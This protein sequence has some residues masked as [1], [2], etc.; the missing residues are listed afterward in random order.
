[1]TIRYSVGTVGIDN[2]NVKALKRILALSATRSVSY[3]VSNNLPAK[4]DIAIVNA[5]DERT[6]F[7]TM[8]TIKA[9]E[10]SV[11]VALATRRTELC[12]HEF[13][14]KLPL[15]G[16]KVIRFLDR[17][18]YLKTGYASESDIA[19]GSSMY[20]IDRVHAHDASK[21]AAS[22]KP[23]KA[24][25][26]P[27]VNKGPDR[28]PHVA[29]VLDDSAVIRKQMQLILQEN[30][31]LPILADTGEKALAIIKSRHVDLA[32]LDVV[33]PDIDGYKVCKQIRKS[34]KSQGIPVVMLTSKSSPFDKMRG[35]LAG[36]DMY[37]TKPVSHKDFKISLAKCQDII[38][39]KPGQRMAG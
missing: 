5:D 28:K 32:F 26:T 30:K 19:D 9:S 24:S 37:L 7:E 39:E 10:K 18:V 29:L 38:R 2:K 4:L 13:A 12:D 21:K 25:V 27:S 20:E 14:I 8:K 31:F 16:S 3:Y 15:L 35:S 1:M 33:L 6:L 34:T 36:C 17:L 23:Q 11:M 22:S